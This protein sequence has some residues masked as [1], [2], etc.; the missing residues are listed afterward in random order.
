MWERR[1]GERAREIGERVNK[2]GGGGLS[3]KW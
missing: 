2:G 1:G 3:R